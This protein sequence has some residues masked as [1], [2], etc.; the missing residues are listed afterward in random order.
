M[1]LALSLHWDGL[2]GV[3]SRQLA[4]ANDH[5]YVLAPFIQLDVLRDILPAS[6]GAT[7]VTSWRWDHL[8]N[9][10]SSPELYQICRERDNVALYIHPSIHLKLYASDVTRRENTALFG[11]ANVTRNGLEDFDGANRELLSR[12]TNL[13]I[14]DRIQIQRVVAES[15]LVDDQVYE[16]H[17]A[18]LADAL[19]VAPPRTIDTVP[20]LIVED[21]GSTYLVTNLPLSSTPSRLL[22]LAQGDLTDVDWWEEDALVHDLALFGPSVNSGA[23]A[24]MES[25]RDSFFES[26][27]V[28]RIAD[29]IDENGM[30]FGELKTWIQGNCED[31]PTPRRRE[32][33][34]TVQSLMQWFTELA[35][36]CYEVVRPRHSECLRRKAKS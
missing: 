9:G 15:I 20:P 11:S 19:L 2:V 3:V 5:V 7:V 29:N 26:P 4:E 10:V 23:D 31:V 8:L 33:T 18:W 16:Q 17:K 32:L 13:S 12:S 22:A 34:Q 1:A 30:Y 35:P 28:R 14:A 36:D 21:E 24:F 25:M 27:F 6:K